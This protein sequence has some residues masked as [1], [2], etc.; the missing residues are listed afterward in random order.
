MEEK[1]K[2]TS[3]YPGLEELK[4]QY[5][6]VGAGASG[7]SFIDTLLSENSTATVI[8]VD[9]NSGPGGHWTKAYPFVRLHQP[10]CYYGVNSHRLGKSSDA[11]GRETF[12][13]DELATGAEIVEYYEE[14]LESFKKTGRVRCLFDAEFEPDSCTIVRKDGIVYRASFDKIVEVRSCV[15]VPAM[16][17]PL[18]PVD[19]EVSFEPVNK[20]HDAIES[21]KFK[22]YIVI[23]AGKTGADAILELVRKGVDQSSITWIVSRDVWYVLRDGIHFENDYYGCVARF[24]APFIEENSENE[25]LLALERLGCIGR[26]QPDGKYPTVFKGPNIT[27]KELEILKSISN[28][29]RLG[30]VVSIVGNCFILEDGMLPFNSKDTYVVDCMVD[31]LYGY[32]DFGENFKF[33]EPNRINLGPT[34]TL[35]NPCFTAA[36]VAYIESTF[37]DDHLKNK[38]CFPVV[39]KHAEPTPELLLASV[40][41]QSKQLLALMSYRPAKKFI[42]SSRTNINAPTHH[43][44]IWKMLWAFFGP[45]QLA[46]FPR[47]MIEKVENGGYDGINHMFGNHRP[48]KICAQ[49]L[50]HALRRRPSKLHFPSSVAAILLVTFVLTWFCKGTFPSACRLNGKLLAPTVVNNNTLPT[51]Q[52]STLFTNNGFG[53]WTS[54]PRGT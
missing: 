13:I 23:G 48:H 21:R 12:N 53:L 33:F 31:R 10:S 46:K 22:K 3:S 17:A 24:L 2:A 41:S 37:E 25:V 7:M 18:V 42:L 39:G 30:R 50:K 36:I 47:A 6:V 15:V 16:R 5:L 45:C 32:Y 54:S 35:F 8:L 4:A 1:T 51:A 9:R 44:G 43:G 14:V 27:K 29:I 26:L 52:K 28:V 38:L 19:D 40:Y 11:Q 20:L 34:L 49:D